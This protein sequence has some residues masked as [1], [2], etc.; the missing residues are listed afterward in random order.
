MHSSAQS[1]IGS[2]T[3]QIAL[4]GVAPFEL[5]GQRKITPPTLRLSISLHIP[6]VINSRDGTDRRILASPVHRPTRGCLATC[7][8][9]KRVYRAIERG[10]VRVECR[11]WTRTSLAIGGS[12]SQ[13]R[14][15]SNFSLTLPSL[16]VLL[17]GMRSNSFLVPPFEITATSIFL[18]TVNSYTADFNSPING[19]STRTGWLI[20]IVSAHPSDGTVSDPGTNW[21]S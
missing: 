9:E 18:S 21:M 8:S 16:G 4:S 5:S 7:G 1:R 20:V 17:A 19:P 15:S 12:R 13:S 14:K 10:R 2:T 11:G 3:L 6:S